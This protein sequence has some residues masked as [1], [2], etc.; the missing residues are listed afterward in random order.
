MELHAHGLEGAGAKMLALQPLE[1]RFLGIEGRALQPLEQWFSGVKGRALQLLEQWFGGSEAEH[2][3]CCRGVLVTSRGVTNTQH[4]THM[5]CELGCL[6]SAKWACHV[7]PE[8]DAW[9]T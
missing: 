5:S 8:G 3:W 6:A 2:G 4:D 9:V 1:Q 7:C